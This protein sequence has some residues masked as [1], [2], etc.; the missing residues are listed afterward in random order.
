MKKK[1]KIEYSIISRGT[2]KY[3]NCGYMAITERVGKYRYIINSDHNV[4]ENTILD[5]S[6]KFIDDFKISN[7]VVS[8][9]E[10]IA[11]LCLTKRSINDDIIIFGLGNIGFATL[12]Y[13]LKKGYKKITIFSN[14]KENIDM[15]EAT[16]NV[17]LSLVNKISRQF[18]TYIDCTGS[19]KIIKMIFENIGFMKD[20]FILSTPRDSKYLIDP[21]EINRKNLSIFGGHEFNGIQNTERNKRFLKILKENEKYSYLLKNY[22]GFHNFSTD[23][24]EKLLK[25]KSNYY[26]I[27]KY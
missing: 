14:K 24:Y 12:L 27:F 4:L 2:E 15:L 21:L 25:K 11:S 20:I 1:V 3:N 23:N 5:N 18:N 13:L 17:K 8:R 7:I 10:L 22:I 6:L 16:F 19:S 9:F 26:D